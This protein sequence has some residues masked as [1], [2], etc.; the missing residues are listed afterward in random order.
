MLTIFLIVG[1]CHNG[2]DQHD[3]PPLSQ[4]RFCNFCPLEDI[5]SNLL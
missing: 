2:V 1:T 4:D 5:V 3:N